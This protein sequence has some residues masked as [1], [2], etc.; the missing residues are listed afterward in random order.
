[1]E[2]DPN[3]S[4]TRGHFAM[5]LLMILGRTDEAIREMRIAGKSDPLSTEMQYFLHMGS[6]W[7]GA[8]M[9]PFLTVRNCQRI[10]ETGRSAWAARYLG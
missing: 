2:L 6:R 3:R 7:R 1:M 8:T 5:N 10:I 9:R 4:A